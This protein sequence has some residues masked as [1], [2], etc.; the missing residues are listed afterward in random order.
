MR[1][2]IALFHGRPF[3]LYLLGHGC[4]L[5]GAW[6]I[7]AFGSMLPLAMG[8]SAGLMLSTPLLCL[9]FKRVTAPARETRRR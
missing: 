9:L 1:K 3:Q 5:F 4:I 6:G 2:V 7:N 8:A